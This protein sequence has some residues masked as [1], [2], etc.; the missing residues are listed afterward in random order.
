MPQNTSPIFLLTP[1]VSWAP[2]GTA[3]NTNLDGTGTV[4]A[5]FT[6]GTNGSKIEKVILEALGTNVATVIRLFVNNGLATSTGTN[7]TLV[8]EIPLAAN[9]ISQTAASARVEVAIDLVLPAGFKLTCSTGTAIA[10]G[11][12][13]TAVGGNY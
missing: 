7:N 6:A 9:T 13:V 2:T 4:A 12:Q 1:V 5:V 3:A 10:A 8:Y 11:V